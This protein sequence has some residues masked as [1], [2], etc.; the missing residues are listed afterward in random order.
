MTMTTPTVYTV[1]EVAEILKVHPR[2]VYRSL[3][4]GTIHGF[5]IGASWRITQEALDAFM[6]GD[7]E[8][9]ER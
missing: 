7:G 2:T 9:R 6:R 3:E 8:R 5:K 1:D 4:A